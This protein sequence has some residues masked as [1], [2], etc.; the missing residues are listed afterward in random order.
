[1]KMF[2]L[3]LT[4]N[5][6]VQLIKS[7]TSFY[8]HALALLYLRYVIDPKDLWSWFE[9][10]LDCEDTFTPSSSN[11]TE[12]CFGTYARELLENQHYYTTMFPRIPVP[13][14]RDIQ[15]RLLTRDSGASCAMYFAARNKYH[16]HNTLCDW[17]M[18]LSA[19]GVYVEEVSKEHDWPVGTRC[20]AK[21][22]ADNLWCART[23]RA[24]CG[25]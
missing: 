11:V 2:Q 12:K 10:E 23:Q 6:I 24:A 9:K 7:E 18:T 8:A 22:S 14:F 16:A 4:K 3:G 19:G 1:M 21:Y 17:M 13:V 5:Q 15:K 25:A 20:K